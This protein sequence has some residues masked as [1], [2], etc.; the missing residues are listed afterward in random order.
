MAT[1]TDPVCGMLSDPRQAAA[2]A[3]HDGFA[4]SFCSEACRCTF[5]GNPEAF[6]GA[7][8]G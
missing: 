2:Q 1:A 8:E 7:D 3:V 5:V 4:Y 6:V